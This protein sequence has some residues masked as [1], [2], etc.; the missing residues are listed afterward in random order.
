MRAIAAIGVGVVLAFGSAAA[1]ADLGP[2]GSPAPQFEPDP[3]FEFGTGWYLRGDVSG[4]TSTQAQI[5]A[6]IAVLP[7]KTSWS[8]DVG[9]GYK[10]NQWFRTDLTLDFA[11]GQRSNAT[12]PNVICPYSLHGLT[13]QG[14]NP[15]QLGYDWS[16]QTGTCNGKASASVSQSNL[17]LNGYFDLGHW[18][19]LTPYIG[20]GVGVARVDANGTLNYYKTSD[21]SVYNTDLSANGNFPLLWV[22]SFGNT[23][24]PQPKIPG[25]TKP[26]G[27]GPQ[28][29]AQSVHK[30]TYNF[31]WSL[32][33]GVA[34]AVD[35]HLSIDV[36]YRYVN[37]GT[38]K[39]LP[40]QANANGVSK[41]LSSQDVRVGLRYMID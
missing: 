3:Q 8:L 40:G 14:V 41:T 24:N 6:D 19:G 33:G 21:G 28:N 31:A 5:S 9:A 26:V 7:S 16:A 11:Q 17:L 37:A 18:Y 10:V 34:Y 29:W 30:T 4:G 22:D 1:G 38:Y 32:T 23:L 27:F 39:S 15:I 12:G 25:T 20:G 36:G 35:D 13:T 2:Y